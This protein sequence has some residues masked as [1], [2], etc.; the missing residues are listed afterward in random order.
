MKKKYIERNKDS[1]A[2]SGYKRAAAAMVAACFLMSGCSSSESTDKTEGNT[3]AATTEAAF[4]SEL[5]VSVE[6][7]DGSFTGSAKKETSVS[8]YSGSGYAGGLS[9]D[10]DAISLTF[11]IEKEGFHDLKFTCSTTGGFKSNYVFVDGES[12]GTIDLDSSAF[13]EVTIPH[14]WMGNGEHEVKIEK[15]WGF[16]NVDKLD[17]MTGAPF[18]TSIYN[19]SPS[20]IDK[21]AS[22]NARRL[23]KFLVDNYGKNVISGQYSEEGAFGREMAAIKKETA[24]TG[25]SLGEGGKLPAMVGLDMS[26]YSPTSVEN[27]GTGTSIEKA[28]NAWENNTIVTMCWHWTAP[29]EYLKGTWYSSFYKEHT[30]IDLDKIMN[31]QDDKG[32]QLLVRDMDAI[33]TELAKL[34]DKDVPVLWRPLHEASGGWF[35]WGNCSAE[36]YIKLY[37]LMYDKFTNEYEL[38]NLIWVWNGQSPLWYPGDDVCD[39]VGTDIYPGEHVYTS[40]YPK[41]IETADIPSYRK[42]VTL[43]ENG[44]L[45]DPDLAVRDGAMWSYFGVWSGDFVTGQGTIITY[46]EQYTDSEMLKKVYNHENVITRDELPVLTEYEMAPLA[47]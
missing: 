37:R 15:Y 1:I 20:L 6:A 22:D 13:T 27:G 35:W 28:I 9:K 12:I 11:N 33:A 16:L 47:E 8:G 3:P 32:Y 38:H 30:S 19:V 25:S 31:G 2:C 46:N 10:G 41:F 14:V 17:V 34:R 36:S 7:E 45:F 42:I 39:I 23:Y 21:K 18:D 29:S 26:Y 24:G 44:C 4:T 43:S 5:V 40:Q